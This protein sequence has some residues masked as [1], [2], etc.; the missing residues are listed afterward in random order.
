MP[1]AQ[2]LR[3]QQLDK[4]QPH[5]LD[6]RLQAQKSGI[7][8]PCPPI[9]RSWAPGPVT[10]LLQRWS[11]GDRAAIDQAIPLVYDE[12]RRM[13]RRQLRHERE[14]HTLQSTSHG[15]RRPATAPS[16]RPCTGCWKP[17]STA[18]ANVPA[19][20]AAHAKAE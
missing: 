9:D 15:R 8:F 4:G 5:P 2:P 10:G 6:V 3:P 7:A 11:E 20:A 19:N 1:V 16:R 13:A 17:C 18:P 12:L 14:G